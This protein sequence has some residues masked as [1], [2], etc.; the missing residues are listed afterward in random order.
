MQKK[1]EI[2]MKETALEESEEM[3]K[4]N[5]HKFIETETQLA[6]ERELKEAALSH[7]E[8]LNTKVQ[9]LEE[10]IEQEKISQAEN[11]DRSA[12]VQDRG[13]IQELEQELFDT[14][15]GKEDLESSEF[16]KDMKIQQTEQELIEVL[17]ER[18]HVKEE[19]EVLTADM[20]LKEKEYVTQ[21]EVIS[22]LEQELNTARLQIQGVEED[23][24]SRLEYRH[25]ETIL[26]STHAD[27]AQS[28]TEIIIGA[29]DNNKSVK[30]RYS[31]QLAS[32]RERL[33]KEMKEH[34]QTREKYSEHNR[35]VKK[36]KQDL[37]RSLDHYK[38]KLCSSEESNKGKIETLEN[39]NTELQ[40]QCNKASSKVADMRRFQ[41]SL[42]RE[43]QQMK[44]QEGYREELRSKV[45]SANIQDK[46][47]QADKDL[48]KVKAS[49]TQAN[50]LNKDYEDSVKSLQTELRNLR[51][52]SLRTES[53]LQQA[54]QQMKADKASLEKLRNTNSSMECASPSDQTDVTGAK[55]NLQTQLDAYKSKLTQE[56]Q[57]LCISEQELQDTRRTL[58]RSENLYQVQIDSWKKL[59]EE[60]KRKYLSYVDK[61]LV[62]ETSLQ[63][64]EENFQLLQRKEI[65]IANQMLQLRQQLREV[66]ECESSQLMSQDQSKE[67]ANQ[68]SQELAYEKASKEEAKV[69]LNELRE[70]NEAQRSE[71]AALKKKV[72]EVQNSN[73]QLS[74]LR[75]E[76]R[77]LKDS[78]LE[79]SKHLNELKREIEE[80]CNVRQNVLKLKQEMASLRT[81]LYSKNDEV[82]M[83]ERTEAINSNEMEQLEGKVLQ[84]RTEIE[85][86]RDELKKLRV[87]LMEAEQQLSHLRTTT[88]KHELHS[89]QW[90]GEQDKLNDVISGQKNDINK[91]QTEL[92]RTRDEVKK[93]KMVVRQL[94]KG[95]L[96]EPERV[97][98]LEDEITECK[99]R[100][101]DL[102]EVREKF[103][104]AKIEAENHS[105]VVNA[106]RED[107]S[108]K[109]MELSKLSEDKQGAEDRNKTLA[110]QLDLQFQ[111]MQKSKDE[112][113]CARLQFQQLMATN[114]K[115]T[116]ELENANK[117]IG[118]RDDNDTLH[119]REEKELKESHY[120]M[121]IQLQQQAKLINYLTDGRPGA[122][123]WSAKM[124]KKE[125]QMN[126]DKHKTPQPILYP[127]RT[128][129]SDSGV[130]SIESDLERFT[131]TDQVFETPNLQ[132]AISDPSPFT[133][134]DIGN[135]YMGYTPLENQRGHGVF[136][137]VKSTLS[138][139]R[140]ETPT[141]NVITGSK[142]LHSKSL[143]EISIPRF[144][145][146]NKLSPVSAVSNTTYSLS[147]C[148]E[149]E[150]NS[151]RS[152]EVD[153]TDMLTSP[154]KKICPEFRAPT[155]R[156][157]PKHFFAAKICK[158]GT[159]C[160]A[161]A[162]PIK[163]G[164]RKEKCA[165]CR[166]VVHP[167]CSST[168]D[169]ISQCQSKLP[170]ISKPDIAASDPQP[171]CDWFKVLFWPCSR[172]VWEKFFIVL[173]DDALLL[174]SEQPAI[175]DRSKATRI[176]SLG[177]YDNAVIS[178]SSEFMRK[179]LN[180]F[181]NTQYAC[182]LFL[183]HEKTPTDSGETVEGVYLQAASNEKKH[184]WIDL[185]VCGIN[186]LEIN[187]NQRAPF[188]MEQIY[189]A[190]LMN[191]LFF[192]S[193]LH[194]KD[195]NIILLAEYTA[196]FF[197]TLPSFIHSWSAPIQIELSQSIA[198]IFCLRIFAE[199][200]LIV[201]IAG[202]E[203]HII[204]TQLESMLEYIGGLLREKKKTNPKF[205]TVP[206]TSGCHIVECGKINEVPYMCSFH[207]DLK[208]TNN[209]IMTHYNVP[210]NYSKCPLQLYNER[211]LAQCASILATTA[212]FFIGSHV[213]I[214]YN[215]PKKLFRESQISIQ[216]TANNETKTLRNPIEIL[217]LPAELEYLLVYSDMGV[218]ISR[219]GGGIFVKEDAV[220]WN[221]TP[222]HAW[223]DE[224]ILFV[225]SSKNVAVYRLV[226]GEIPSDPSIYKLNSNGHFLCYFPTNKSMLYTCSEG[227]TSVIYS[228][229]FFF[230]SMV[231]KTNSRGEIK[232][233]SSTLKRSKTNSLTDM[234]ESVL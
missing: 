7:V 125:L 144:D 4:L 184:M 136:E 98:E 182:T 225:L 73:S 191:N 196:L 34:A 164:E 43:I 209:R 162:L 110:L 88:S 48:N 30:S 11:N 148:S 190:P 132:Q 175:P 19:L 179:R 44:K 138:G 86:S 69:R 104:K 197:L 127:P 72:E 45:S 121:E 188:L 63:T 202:R 92:M 51:S 2:E 233:V 224:D 159:V 171:A 161:C 20:D 226:K 158:S 183:L 219:Y 113:T 71:I 55:N 93:L 84:Q 217:A 133:F 77:A 223:I 195:H 198:P 50:K 157:I 212:K 178:V 206:N 99:T 185:L 146:E 37:E 174:Y 74:S 101:Q 13:R 10:L 58:Q 8:H 52:N 5:K 54:N 151:K 35:V 218:V 116:I 205:I 76:Y 192:F 228:C 166:A 21:R 122:S 78:E 194:F 79:N 111:E 70:K 215:P 114:H 57:R 128:N 230:H 22:E 213:I 231:K 155:G 154:P 150:G 149:S 46:I 29:A 25:K 135:E 160:D 189:N 17:A 67:H 126:K 167:K 56:S 177:P 170:T 115:L 68:L 65:G 96:K 143:K 94:E 118:S 26:S 214:S 141:A 200:G 97:L 6:Q 83:R 87:E 221:T 75:A 207:H 181:S 36:K 89:A 23:T 153:E 15:R 201:M 47:K 139:R 95:N 81:E 16:T 176:L 1:R 18:D 117:Q 85:G 123:K 145:S 131:P 38:S 172:Q 120:R 199:M 27:G 108:S 142:Q 203:R 24:H 91:V 66:S 130:T 64:K 61:N 193:A 42:E 14:T 140:F 169:S 208:G 80:N 229:K 204:V 82:S 33:D 103:N 107:N 168:Y 41:T 59:H 124:R 9:T 234:T 227:E 105:R 137:R 156:L 102:E 53:Q 173:A 152:K 100:I 165:F 106:L 28:D 60:E 3:L 186:E 119:T 40:N 210:S 129:G 32:I 180:A 109:E 49:L 31:A 211:P 39:R 12:S 216:N 163:F 134:E 62:L 220:V 90:T 187:R 222:V 147:S 232:P 112:S